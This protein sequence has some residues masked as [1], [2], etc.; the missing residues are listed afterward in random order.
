MEGR[1]RA[2]DVVR[3]QLREAVAARK[4]HGC[5]C[6]HKTVEALEGTEDGR[7]ELAASLA[8]AHTVFTPK[9]YDCLGCE[10]CYPAIAA[11]AFADA[12]PGAG[13]SLDLCPT[14]S[15][16]ARSGWPPLPGDY[17]LVRYRAPVAR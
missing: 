2:L 1:E 12:F 9:K 6:L 5:G 10:V 15:P 17:H 11:N 3:E 13:E 8:E 14:E 16:E 4:C 7:G